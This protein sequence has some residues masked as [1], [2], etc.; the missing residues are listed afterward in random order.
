MK[1]TIL[2]TLVLCL[3]MSSVSCGSSDNQESTAEIRKIGITLS[4]GDDSICRDLGE[5]LSK[6][7]DELS[8][9]KTLYKVNMIDASRSANGQCNHVDLFVSS[10]Y[11]T[12]IVDLIDEAKAYDIAKIAVQNGVNVVFTGRTY[13]EEMTEQI[14]DEVRSA[15]DEEIEFENACR[16]QLSALRD[17]SGVYGKVLLGAVYCAGKQNAARLVEPGR[18]SYIG[19]YAPLIGQ[20]FADIMDSLPLGGDIDGSG[21]IEYAVISAGKETPN[22]KPAMNHM[23]EILN[24]KGVA[25]GKVKTIAANDRESAVESLNKILASNDPPDIVFAMSDEALDYADEALTSQ[26][27]K[28]GKDIHLIAVSSGMVD[29]SGKIPDLLSGAVICNTTVL[30]EKIAQAVKGYEDGTENGGA[31]YLDIGLVY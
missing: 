6:A 20:G 1:R 27:M 29:L 25:S 30:A 2:L 21:S 9:E 3:L 15:V 10:G 22:S 19:Y 18:I 11:D 16:E 14:Y 17:T 13:P 7:I 28:A 31:E 4:A 26:E 12:I 5:T 24:E 23:T 8:N